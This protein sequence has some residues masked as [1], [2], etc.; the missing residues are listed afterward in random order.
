M[1]SLWSNRRMGQHIS[2]NTQN[3]L[4]SASD[5]IPHHTT[6]LKVTRSNKSS[7]PTETCPSS[8][9]KRS[10]AS[11]GKLTTWQT[12]NRAY[13]EFRRASI[14]KIHVAARGIQ[15]LTSK[16]SAQLAGKSR[17]NEV[18]YPRK[19]DR[20]HFA[21]VND[22]EGYASANSLNFGTLTEPHSAHHRG[23]FA[24]AFEFA[25]YT[26]GWYR[27]DDPATFRR[28]IGLSSQIA[29]G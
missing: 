8:L 12:G 22:V 14:S 15:E 1:K 29:V 7:N 13:D 18:A 6:S 16:R 21:T 5:C 27:S 26:S 20:A 24:G 25:A 4:M 11:A 17:H 3:V 19:S 10:G 28:A 9:I 23:E 2:S